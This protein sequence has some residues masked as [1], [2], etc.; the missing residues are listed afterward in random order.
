MAIEARLDCLT[1]INSPHK[2]ME[3]A[4]Y[5]LLQPSKRLRPLLLLSILDGYQVPL[6]HGLDAACSLEMIHTYSLIHDD[7]PCMDN[8]DF[9]R[10]FP[11]VHKKFDEAI[12]LLAGDFLLTFAFEVLSKCSYISPS[13]KCDLISLLSHSC[14]AFGMIQGQMLDLDFPPFTKKAVN[15]FLYEKKTACLFMASLEMGGRISLLCDETL[16]TLKNLGKSF[17]LAYQYLDDLEDKDQDNNEILQDSK[18]QAHHAKKILSFLN[19][20]RNEIKKLPKPSPFLYYLLEY[21]FK[22][23][24]DSL[25]KSLSCS[26]I[27]LSKEYLI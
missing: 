6:E 11:S 3:A 13:L 23:N 2:V 14:G 27:T 4:R 21:P 26:P 9:R 19:E 16:Q 20:A 24:I 10:G 17:G 22:K 12:A 5:I 18:E 7:L 1:A 15:E 25:A 8:D